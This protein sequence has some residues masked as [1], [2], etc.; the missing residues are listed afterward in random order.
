MI[1][2]LNGELIPSKRLASSQTVVKDLEVITEQL[3][4]GKLFKYYIL[5]NIILD[6][7]IDI[8]LLKPLNNI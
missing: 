6:V 3:G 7:Y 5:C 8:E 1:D 4:L 2:P